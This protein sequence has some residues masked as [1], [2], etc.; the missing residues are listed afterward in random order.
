M[1]D[2]IRENSQGTIAKV[3]LGFVILTFAIAGVGSYTNSVDTSVA[4]VNGEKISQQTF[5]QAYQAQKRRMQQQFGDMFDTL[6]ADATYLANFR[7]DVLDNLINEKLIDQSANELALRVSSARLKETIRTMPEFQVDG[8]FDNNRYLA[9]INQAGFFQSSDFRDYLKVE[10][11]RRQLSQGLV[12][13]E[14]GLPYQAG[15]MSKL[16]NQTRDFRYLVINAAQFNQHVTLT[17]EEINQYYQQHSAQFETPEQVKLNYVA[18]D[19][20]KIQQSL[21]VTDADIKSYYQENI[22]NYTS[23]EQRKIA[24][25]LIEFGDDEAAAQVSIEQVQDE[26][27]Q[28]ADFALLAQQHSADTYSGEQ[29]GDLGWLEP[30]VMDPAFETAAFA[31]AKSGEVSSIVKSSFGFHLIKLTELKGE[32][33]KALAEVRDEVQAKLTHERAQDKF[34]EL[35]QELARVSFEYPDNLE[36]AAKTVGAQVQTSDW[37]VRVGNRAPFDNARLLEAAFSDMVLQDR[38][39]SEVIEVA[40]GLAMVVRLNEHKVAKVKALDDVKAGI[41]QTLIADKASAIAVTKADEIVTKLQQGADISAD[42]QALSSEFITQT[43]VTRNDSKLEAALRKQAFVLPHPLEGKMSVGTATLANGDLAVIQVHAV[44]TPEVN[45]S[46]TTSLAQQQM[47]Q[48][49]QSA[50]QNYVAT[51]KADAK[52]SRKAIKAPVNNY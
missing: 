32:T 36:D 50:Y 39:N 2:N 34:F 23:T 31:L 33:I 19:V 28:G 49:A 52:I 45:N 1:L 11:T 3:I 29:G 6:S 51:L 30:G 21:V 18:V 13:T 42:A 26:L 5:E 46:E 40:D 37:L 24:H 47:S 12:A 17:D 20:N 41:E 9:L 16:Q 15:L 8:T 35:Q 43:D 44:K 22:A 38:A 4:E 25:I 7:N 14:F 48:L 27:S 10:M